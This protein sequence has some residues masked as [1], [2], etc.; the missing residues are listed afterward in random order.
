MGFTKKEMEEK[1]FTPEQIDFVMA[2]R[3]KEIEKNY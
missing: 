3:G 2:E 1:G